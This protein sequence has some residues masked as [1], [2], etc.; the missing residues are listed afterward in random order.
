MPRLRARSVELTRTLEALVAGIE[1]VEQITPAD[2]ERR[3]AMLTL[4]L[5]VP[6]SEV[7][8]RLGAA[9]VI[10]DARPPR[11]LR[12]APAP[13]YNSYEDLWRFGEALKTA[14]AGVV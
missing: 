9:G 12:V 6:T 2:P 13:L 1:G 4:R 3:G 7:V 10:V 8:R 11:I 5:P 14:L